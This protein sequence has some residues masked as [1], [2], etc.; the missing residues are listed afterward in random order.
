MRPAPRSV[1]VVLMGLAVVVASLAIATPAAALPDPDDPTIVLSP[2][3]GPPGTEITVAGGN[4]YL[5]A[6]TDPTR[7]TQV[8]VSA[9]NGTR[10]IDLDTTA[11]PGPA[12]PFV[13]RTTG[14]SP[15]GSD[16]VITA[17]FVIPTVAPSEG[18]YVILNCPGPTDAGRSNVAFFTVTYSDG[19]AAAVETPKGTAYVASTV[20]TL[21][22]VTNTA[23]FPGTL[24]AG[25]TFPYGVF[26]FTIS[27][28]DPGQTAFVTMK[29][30]GEFA[31]AWEY[32]KYVSGAWIF[33]TDGMAEDN[34]LAFSITDG[35][36]FDS[37]GLANGTIV[38]PGAP[39]QPALAA[40]GMDARQFAPMT[41][42]GFGT[43]GT[44]IVLLLLFRRRRR[45]AEQQY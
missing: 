15:D 30:P 10:F 12:V 40:T 5:N 29:M 13:T 7:P 37:D 42:V 32:W 21:S 19:A 18:Y 4:C 26:T 11:N 2:S 43:I 44:G 28:L 25:K 1:R 27:D 16:D 36:P 39:G 24:P 35:G 23:E 9:G 8:K 45:R 33:L 17:K 38:D 14:A 20:G 31:G 3:S 41:L 34:T 6:E 22:N